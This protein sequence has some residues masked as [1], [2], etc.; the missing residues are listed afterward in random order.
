MWARLAVIFGSL[1]VLF[2][3]T[4]LIG[5]LILNARYSG[6][7]D[8][9]DLL[10]DGERRSSIDSNQPLNMVLVGIDARPESDEPVRGDTI[11]VVHIPKGHQRAYLLSLPRDLRV[12]IPASPPHR[13]RATRDRLN[14]A[15]P[16][17]AED[18]RGIEGGFQ[19][20]SRTITNLTG[21]SPDAAAVINFDGFRAVVRELGGI[22]MCLDHRIV[23]EH[24]GVARDGKSYQHPRDG[25]KPWV[26]E[27]GCRKFNDWEALDV[28]RQR[29]SLPDGDF[30]RQRNQQRFLKG[31]LQAA[32]SKGVVSDPR[33][34]DA[35]VRAA[36]K[37]L[38]FDGNN[39]APAEWAFALRGIGEDSLV[40]LRTPTHSV[41]EGNNYL[42][43]DLDPTAQD[44]FTALRED[45]ID[46]YI[47]SHPEVVNPG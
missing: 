28:V 7:I 44:L 25:G 12:E 36:G 37:A 11:I 26:Y 23:S 40:M 35:I 9:K 21:I 30:G 31:M 2:S 18:N 42:G 5:G 19:L 33:K 41:G 4:A 16:Y 22:T 8:Q 34:L 29:K 27:A 32:K 14:A 46:E 13:Q 43:E 15:F 24:M 20:L 6:S 38:T 39:I 47:A 1:L 17:G 10:P 3:G 45:R